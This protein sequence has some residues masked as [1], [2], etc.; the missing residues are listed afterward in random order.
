M[1]GIDVFV[2]YVN[3]WVVMHQKFIVYSFRKKV[4]EVAPLRLKAEQKGKGLA[5]LVDCTLNLIF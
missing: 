1:L 3:E 4:S 5:P 2:L